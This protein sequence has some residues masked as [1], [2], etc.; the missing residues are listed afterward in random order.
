MVSKRRLQ[1]GVHSL[2][3][4]KRGETVS[5]ESSIQ[6]DVNYAFHKSLLQKYLF[7]GEYRSGGA[8]RHIFAR[9]MGILQ[10][11]HNVTLKIRVGWMP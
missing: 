2:I 5:G 11:P 3:I 8:L 4:H 7:R 10:E 6:T 9:C 1:Y